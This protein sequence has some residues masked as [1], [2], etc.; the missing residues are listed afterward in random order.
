[1]KGWLN[2]T[3]KGKFPEY[4]TPSAPTPIHLVDTSKKFILFYV[5]QA[6]LVVTSECRSKG[7]R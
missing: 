6:H 5:F 1:M 4:P 3:S 2:K 7:M